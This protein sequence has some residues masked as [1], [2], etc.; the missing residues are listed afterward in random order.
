MTKT[1]PDVHTFCDAVPVAGLG[2]QEENRSI[3]PI[4]KFSGSVLGQ[5][6]KQTWA[7]R[8]EIYRIRRREAGR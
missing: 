2:G 6:G 5:E 7:F 4:S 3:G 1:M 8:Q